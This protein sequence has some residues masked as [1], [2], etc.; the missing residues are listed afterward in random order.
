MSRLQFLR[1]PH[2]NVNREGQTRAKVRVH[3]NKITVLVFCCVPPDKAQK[4]NVRCLWGNVQNDKGGDLLTGS[5]FVLASGLSLSVTASRTGFLLEGASC[6][7]SIG[8]SSVLGA[9]GS[10]SFAS[11]LGSSAKVQ[12]RKKQKMCANVPSRYC[13]YFRWMLRVLLSYL[14]HW[15]AVVHH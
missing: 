12:K 8:A 2:T 9:A 15:L 11:S 7:N 10:C 6:C 1:A 13:T 5:A 14:Q 4:P 3:M